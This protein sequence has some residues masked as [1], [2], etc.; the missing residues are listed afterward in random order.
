[1]SAPAIA[2]D[3]L[4]KYYG[5]VVG[6]EQLSLTVEPGEVFGFLG[7]NGAGKTTAIRLMM[8]L[9]RPTSGRA[10]VLGFD[11]HREALEARRRIGYLPGETPLYPELTG[12]AYLKFL[13]S[14][15]PRP[16]APARLDALF[17]RFDVSDLDLQRRMRDYSHGMKRK[18]GIIQAL[19]SGPEVLILDEP[20]SGLDPLMIDAFAEEIAGLA[21]T[22]RTTV[23]LSSHVLS[24]V[25]R[26]CSRIALIR[27]G[28]LVTVRRLDDLRGTHPRRVTILFSQPVAA[29]VPELAG[30]TTVSRRDREWVLDVTGPLGPLVAA[31]GGLPV[32]DIHYSTPTLEEIVLRLFVDAKP[33]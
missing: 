13:G 12:A 8:D 9:L 32:D 28:S 29:S 19:M 30:I 22:G 21:A 33:C 7:A 1:M 11:C 24:E 5:R 16:P 25:E 4:T 6:L 10:A 3:G 20:T 2:L 15:G 31:L 18:L 14:I 23:F 27:R 17:R 26:I